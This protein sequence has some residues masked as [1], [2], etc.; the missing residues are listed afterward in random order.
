LSSRIYSSTSQASIFKRMAG[1]RKRVATICNPA[2]PDNSLFV[3]ELDPGVHFGMPPLFWFPCDAG[4]L[5][6]IYFKR[7]IVG[8]IYNPAHLLAALRE[9]GYEV[10][11]EYPKSDRP[12]FEIRKAVADGTAA[13]EGLDF[14]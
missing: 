13:I 14:Y 6:K 9:R 2:L 11:T 8:T 4:F 12:K 5:E 10:R 3:S 1:I 7:A